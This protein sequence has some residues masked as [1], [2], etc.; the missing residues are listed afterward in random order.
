[1]GKKSRNDGLKMYKYVVYLKNT[2]LS[3]C[4]IWTTYITKKYKN[5][6]KREWKILQVRGQREYGFFPT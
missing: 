1:M 2:D 6:D 4:T 5:G 3:H